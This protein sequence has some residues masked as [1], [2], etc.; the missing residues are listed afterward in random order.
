MLTQPPGPIA[1][2]IPLHITTTNIRGALFNDYNPPVPCRQPP[3][4]EVDLAW[5]AIT[6]L[7]DFGITAEQLLKMGKDPNIAVKIPADWGLGEDLF[8][9][10]LDSQRHLHCLN[11]LRKMV[12]LGLISGDGIR[13]CES[14]SLIPIPLPP[15]SSSVSVHL[16]LSLSLYIYATVMT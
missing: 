4:P 6:Q 13:L 11:A 3:S 1:T 10:Q 14:L 7:Q 15:F 9:A 12:I 8:L 16:F 2:R 5:D